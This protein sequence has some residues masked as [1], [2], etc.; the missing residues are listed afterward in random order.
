METCVTCPVG[1]LRGSGLRIVSGMSPPNHRRLRGHGALLLPTVLAA[2]SW[3]AMITAGHAQNSASASAMPYLVQSWQTEH[4]LPQ[5]YVTSIAQTTDGYLWIGTY[6]GLAR[7]DGVR[8]VNFDPENTPALKHPH[9]QRLFTDAQGT[10][11]I[12]LVDGSL[13][14]RRH[15]VLRAEWRG[16]SADGAAGR[17][18]WSRTDEV[19][20]A[21]S[22][23]RL[24]Q[25]KLTAGGSNEWKV[26]T[27]KLKISNCYAD[28]HGTLLARA[29]DGGLVRWTGQNFERLP[30]LL[31]PAG[32]KIRT[33]LADNVGKLWVGT[34][35]EI[36]VW[37][38][39]A[40]GPQS[41]FDP[42]AEGRFISMTPTNGEPV[43]DVSSLL[44]TTEGSL[45]VTAN[46]QTR[47]CR[48]RQWV[49]DAPAWNSRTEQQLASFGYYGDREGGMWVHFGTG[50]VHIR[51]DGELRRITTEDGLANDRVSCWFQDREGSIWVGQNR[52][53]LVR[54]RPRDFQVL[55][56]AEGLSDQV[57]M[58]LCEDGDGAMWIGTYG[59]GLNRWQEG[60]F[61]PFNLGSSETPGVVV[62]VCPD[63]QGRV[64]VGTAGN[65]LFCRD[66]GEFKRLV[67][68]A[69]IDSRA[70]ALY[71]DRE[72]RLWIGNRRGLFRWA[73]GKL[74]QFKATDGFRSSDVRAFSQDASGAMWIGAT[75]GAIYR[76]HDERFTTFRPEDALAK[77]PIWSLHADDA[78]AVWI[79]TF[80]GGLLRLKDGRFTRYTQREGLPN[81]VICHILDDQKGRFW[82]S[83][84]QGIFRVAR[85]DLEA[86]AHG[87]RT[88]APCVAYGKHDGLPT[89]E[90][91][92]NYSPAGWRSRD[93]RLW[94]ATVKGVVSVQ[95]DEVTVNP[96]PPPVVIEKLLV[97][98][99]PARG[100]PVASAASSDITQTQNLQPPASAPP[101]AVNLGPG[102]HHLEFH[103]T[104]LSLRAPDKV[105]FQ[106]MLEGLDQGWLDNGTKRTASYSYVPPGEYQFRVR[107]C[108]NDGV[109]NESGAMLALSVVPYFWQTRWFLAGSALG[110][111]MMAGALIRFV[112]KRRLKRRLERLERE[113]A[114]ERERS[115]IAQDIHDDL[116]ASLTRITLLSE[117][118]REAHE[119]ES[120]AGRSPGSPPEIDQIYSTARELT[121]AMDEIVWAVNP[122]H[123][124]L[125]SLATYLGKFAQ[126]FL[127]AAN[128]RCRLD[129]PVQ[130]PAMPLTSEVRHN[131][132]LAFKESL[133][134]AVRHAAAS[135]V[136]IQL[137]VDDQEFRLT[138]EDN[139]RG[140]VLPG[141]AA[142]STP[143]NGSDAGRLS[144]GHGL[145]NMRRRL[146][147]ISGQCEIAGRAGTGTK[148]TFTVA[149]GPRRPE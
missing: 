116:G 29:S 148:V 56:V 95:P 138:V 99:V 75:D 11:W 41:L 68:S 130:L 143:A 21:L 61:T 30:P 140:F 135:E 14:S 109:W 43:L 27:P 73:D 7:F 139:G 96:L 26:I 13:A 77:Q 40:T 67:P 6:N 85:A 35:K 34:E 53:G 28:R 121:R 74:R 119:S 44:P 92:G 2:I 25:G 149:T 5:N 123:D 97:D 20:F 120:G 122:Q 112:E 115:R 31:G 81:N 106:Y 62:S 126:D 39:S 36:A 100:L 89:V 102:R 8:F 37:E 49:A 114:I 12:A 94:F 64:W 19:L 54:L 105:Q 79:G 46:G 78:G 71:S 93:G 127:R 147:E 132:F 24:L 101:A 16:V 111:A 145:A 136:R 125:D 107:A 128:I 50:L 137:A 42:P 45:W 129:L 87:D 110:L 83:S 69:P 84:H 60:A 23:G 63:Q 144:T 103:F 91:S 22:S 76:F 141:N 58:S 118:V 134:N 38:S 59:G 48:E 15:G 124:T 146:Q 4:G 108:N 70:Y 88:T 104:G 98:G 1:L 82:I 133:H 47:R 86:V 57:A 90:C 55:G 131:L 117:A 66:N 9:V 17:L 10:L 142:A 3:W 32:K 33:L 113:R 80:R 72:N 51:P 65:G 18:L 52:G